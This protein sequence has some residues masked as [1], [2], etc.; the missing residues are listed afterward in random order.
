MIYSSREKYVLKCKKSSKFL[1]EKN[2]ICIV[3]LKTRF[4]KRDKTNI[5]YQDFYSHMIFKR[6][7]NINVQQ[8]HSN[9]N[10]TDLFIKS[11]PTATFEKMVHKI[12]M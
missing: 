3:Q 6:M 1:Y 4:I 9:N 8:I 12:E 5:F 10:I 11:L 2:V 7:M